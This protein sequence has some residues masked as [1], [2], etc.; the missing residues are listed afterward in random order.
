MTIG[1]IVIV[2]YWAIFTVRKGFTP[3]LALKLK[4][5]AYDRKGSNEE[6]KKAAERQYY[7]LEAARWILKIAVWT[8]NVLLIALIA[9]IIFLIGAIM[10]G[11]T[12]ILG[13]PV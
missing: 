11:G 5:N 3:K 12:V 7:P 1:S 2:L 9:W 6:A 8:E 10:T 13:Y 4:A